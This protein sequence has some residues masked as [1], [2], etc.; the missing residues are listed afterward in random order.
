VEGETMTRQPNWQ[1]LCNL[2]D[3]NPIDH[4]GV[5]VYLDKNCIYTPEME[6]LEPSGE[7]DYGDPTTWTVYRFSLDKCTYINGILSDNPYHPDHPAWF[8][9]PESERAARPQDTTYLQNLQN[10]SYPGNSLPRALCSDDIVERAQ[11][12]RAIYEYHGLE[13]FDS[14]P[15]TFDNREEVEE[16]CANHEGVKR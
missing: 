2:G 9:K 13:N 12:Y 11:A 7:D 4:G 3:A 14:Y 1:L 6:V 16:R 5:F 10:D 15:L 8:A